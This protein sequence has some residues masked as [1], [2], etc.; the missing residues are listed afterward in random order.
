MRVGPWIDES[1]ER[2]RQRRT[3]GLAFALGVAPWSIFLATAVALVLGYHPAIEVV[4]P[5]FAVAL[6]L[7]VG[8]M[9]MGAGSKDRR[10]RTGFLL[11]C[12]TPVMILLMSG[13][14]CLIQL[15]SYPYLK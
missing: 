14:A 1:P 2:C 12:L 15:R 6:A 4:A 10:A 11:G 3:S 5:G 13:A 8:G 9:V 7:G